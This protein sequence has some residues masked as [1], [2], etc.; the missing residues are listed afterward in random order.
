MPVAGDFLQFAEF[1]FDPP[2]L[3][4]INNHHLVGERIAAG[5]RSDQHL[6]GYS[7]EI[8]EQIDFR[9]LLPRSLTAP[10]QQSHKTC[11]IMPRDEYQEWPLEKPRH[12]KSQEARRRFIQ[13]N[14]AS[15]PV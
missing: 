3:A 8:D 2:L 14:D 7:L 11:H 15:T 4:Q 9:C 13:F 1:L 10:S 12:G 6:N 5:S